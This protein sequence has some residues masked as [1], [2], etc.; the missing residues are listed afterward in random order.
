VTSLFLRIITKLDVARIPW[1]ENLF[2]AEVLRCCSRKGKRL[3]VEVKSSNVKIQISN[4][5]Q[6]PKGKIEM[7]NNIKE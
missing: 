3:E 6:I 7:T 2:G 4:Y 1:R 5:V